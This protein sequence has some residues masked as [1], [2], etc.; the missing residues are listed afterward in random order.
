MQAALDAIERR[1]GHV[2]SALEQIGLR[3][4]RHC[5]RYFRRSEPGLLFDCRGPVCVECIPEWRAELSTELTVNERATVERQLTQWL[6]VYHQGTIVR[7]S[8]KVPEPQLLKVRV[9]VG[10]ERCQGTGRVSNSRCRYCDGRGTVWVVVPKE[11]QQ[12]EI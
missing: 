8:R 11:A 4:C 7:E 3:A 2:E 9:V 12:A 10:C 6:L 1:L 5:K